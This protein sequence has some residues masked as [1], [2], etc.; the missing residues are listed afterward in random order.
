VLGWAALVEV[1]CT[2]G[3]TVAGHPGR[4]LPARVG[5][6]GHA[7]AVIYHEARFHRGHQRQLATIPH[8]ELLQLPR[9][10]P[11]GGRKEE[12]ETTETTQGRGSGGRRGG[13]CV[14]GGR[15]EIASHPPPFTALRFWASRVCGE[16]AW[17]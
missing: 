3:V 13:L 14:Q 5:P 16:A 4:G 6:P 12:G 10:E 8:A 1:G 7:P 2:W 17:V 9:T 11:A 15:A